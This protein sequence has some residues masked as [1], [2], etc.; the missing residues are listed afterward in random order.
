MYF[1]YSEHVYIYKYKEKN[2]NIKHL[3]SLGN[4]LEISYL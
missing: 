3:V 2:I 4:F 1:I